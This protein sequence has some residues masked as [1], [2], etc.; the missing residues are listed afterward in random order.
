[1][2]LETK[3]TLILSDKDGN[4]VKIETTFKELLNTSEEE[5]IDNLEEGCV[6]S[7][8]YNESQSFCDCGGMYE[9]YEVTEVL[10][11]K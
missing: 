3:V 11:E 6:S 4:K 8:C 2:K 1:M 9:D 5:Y 10:L 7:G